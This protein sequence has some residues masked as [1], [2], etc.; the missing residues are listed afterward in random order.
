[1]TLKDLARA[2]AS[3]RKES[4]ADVE[5]ILAAGFEAI[6]AEVKSGEKVAIHEF[7][8]FA[9]V[10]KEATVARNPSTGAKVDV[11]AKTVVKFKPSK[12]LVDLLKS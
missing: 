7:G 3:K 4:Q 8:I 2:V 1:M 11:A 10:H 6:K 5:A 9:P 12:A